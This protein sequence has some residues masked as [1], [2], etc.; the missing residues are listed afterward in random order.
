[1]AIPSW[2]PIA[3]LGISAVMMWLALESRKER[4]QE[5]QAGI[6]LTLPPGAELWTPQQIQEWF[7]QSRR[8]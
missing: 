4:Q 1:M 6:T 8:Q 3:G 5:Q 2:V 7:E